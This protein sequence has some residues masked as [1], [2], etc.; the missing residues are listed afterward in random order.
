MATNKFDIRLV[1]T[2]GEEDLNPVYGEI[3]EG[4]TVTQLPKINELVNKLNQNLRLC[5]F[6]DI[7]VHAVINKKNN[8][9][10]SFFPW[11]IICG[12]FHCSKY[13]K[14]FPRIV[15][16]TFD[17]SN[18]GKDYVTKGMF[19]PLTHEINCAYSITDFDVLMGILPETLETL[20]VEPKLIK[21]NF[22]LKDHEHR[23]KTLTFIDMY[24]NLTILDTNGNNLLN[25]LQ[26][27]DKDF[28]NK[29]LESEA[30]KIE[31]ITSVIQETFEIKINGK[32]MDVKEILA[33]CRTLPE[34]NSYSDDALERLIRNV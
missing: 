13:S 2:H 3:L 26:E 32:H 22:L 31:Q 19:L 12:S 6:G 28:E 23:L 11:L 20:V 1:V 33:Y 29:K 18:L 9:D 16:E 21:K 25:V 30:K 27:I 4:F 14:N 10:D 24:P 5:I 8:F 15:S 34:Y 17:C 7:D